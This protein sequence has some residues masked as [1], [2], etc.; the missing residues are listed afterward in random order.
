RSGTGRRASSRRTR[1]C[2]SSRPWR[3]PASSPEGFPT[4]Q[5]FGTFRR[6][7]LAETLEI[8][9]ELMPA[10]PVLA[11]GSSA[12]TYAELYDAAARARAW[13]EE[14]GAAP[15]G[16]VATLEG[17]TPR[18]FALLYGALAI[19]ATLA[20]LNP[21]AKA[22]ELAALLDRLAPDLLIAEERY[23]PVVE[24]TGAPFVAAADLT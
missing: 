3:S 22:P 5:T 11:D 17:F 24:A 10:V 16:V 7:N 15:G 21:R 4:Y 9:A 18:F 20:P 14:H 12:W 23:Q 6:V 1:S 2:A 19:G 8:P 13:L